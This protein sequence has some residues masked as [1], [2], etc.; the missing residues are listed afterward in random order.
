MWESDDVQVQDVASD[1]VA[2]LPVDEYLAGDLLDLGAAE[3]TIGIDVS[4]AEGAGETTSFEATAPVV[5]VDAAT[6]W[7]IEPTV[8]VGDGGPSGLAGARQD[9]AVGVAQEAEGDAALAS[10]TSTPVS[11][12]AVADDSGQ[13]ASCSPLLC[14]NRCGLLPRCCTDEGTCACRDLVTRQCSLPSLWP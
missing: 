3:S 10:E 11:S 5:G 7:A 2:A 13:A 8:T 14:F 4:M 12:L 6:G 9:A 1:D